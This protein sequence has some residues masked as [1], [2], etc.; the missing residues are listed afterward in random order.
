MCACECLCVSLSECACECMRM[1]TGVSI[2]VRVRVSV[3]ER[4]SVTACQYVP[5]SQSCRPT[6]VCDS[7]VLEE[8]VLPFNNPV[9]QT[10]KVPFKAI[11]GNL[12]LLNHPHP[13]ESVMRACTCVLTE[14]LPSVETFHT[15]KAVWP[16]HP[17]EW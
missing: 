13:E 8:L 12:H 1:C 3:F 14:A 15:E 6:I 9:C 16:D 10:H 2:C 17:S 5:Y 11:G 7:S 4:D